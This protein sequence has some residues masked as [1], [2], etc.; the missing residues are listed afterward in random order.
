MIHKLQVL[1]VHDVDALQLLLVGL[2]QVENDLAKLREIKLV[3]IQIQNLNGAEL[4]NFTPKEREKT[5]LGDPY[6]VTSSSHR[7]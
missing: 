1:L 3:I 6:L 4:R 2:V 7:T 5:E